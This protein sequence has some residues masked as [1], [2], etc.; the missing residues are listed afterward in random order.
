M[1]SLLRQPSALA[2]G[3]TVAVEAINGVNAADS[4]AGGQPHLGRLSGRGAGQ[5]IRSAPTRSART[6]GITDVQF[7]WEMLGGRQRG[8]LQVG[9]SVQIDAA[10]DALPSS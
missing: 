3:L 4:P 8:S 7:V 2:D 6:A 1:I 10:G 5:R 9:D